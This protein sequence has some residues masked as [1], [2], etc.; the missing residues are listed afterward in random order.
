MNLTQL[1]ARFRGD[2]DDTAEPYLWSDAEVTQ[3]LVEAEHEA[4][5]RARL[6]V[7][8]TTAEFCRLAVTAGDPWVSINPR[9]LLIRRARLASESRPL[10]LMTQR[11]MDEEQPNWETRGSGTPKVLIT[12]AETNRVRLWPAPAAAGTLHLTL[13][14]LPTA[15]LSVGADTPQIA[16]HLHVKLVAWARHRAYLKPDPDTRDDRRSLEALVEFERE[17]GPPVSAA[18][19]LFDLRN[20]PA[21]GVDGTY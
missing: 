1:I 21:E 14:R 10:Y 8:S 16:P 6:L 9:T 12:D 7:D 13:S 17:F 19:E 11:V 15:D 20:L 18:S 2:V 5:R 4:C 3:Y